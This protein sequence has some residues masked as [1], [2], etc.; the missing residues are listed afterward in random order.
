[1]VVTVMANLGLRRALEGAG[2]SILE[3]QV[4]DRYVLE[5]MVRSGVTLGGEQS[6]HVIFLDH[7]TTGDGI[8][9][10][11]RFLSLARRKGMPV[12]TLAGAMERYPQ[13]LEN[14][15]V[16]STAGLD[17]QPAILGSIESDRLALGDRGRVL[18]RP[19]GTEPLVRVMVE[20]ETEQDAREH[21]GRVAAA[22]RDALGSSEADSRVP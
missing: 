12:A 10:A 6:G 22:V 19:A 2:I 3:T 20:A 9:T 4:G 15:K 18:V 11:V 8:L 13:V 5:E 1:V 16:A 7:A 21:A 14:V 17:G